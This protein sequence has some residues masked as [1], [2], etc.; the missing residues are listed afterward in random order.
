MLH[1]G[2]RIELTTDPEDFAVCAQ[3]MSATD[4]WI[5]MGVD[6]EQCL[7]AFDGSHREVFVLKKEREVI[8]FVIIQ[9]LGT[10]KGY[11]QTLAINAANRGAGYGTLL[12]QFCAERILQYSPNI[13]ICVS[14]FNTK[15]LQLYTKFGFELVGELKDFLKD[16]FSELLLRKTA[17][18]VTGYTPLP[19]KF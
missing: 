15:A 18:P 19:S 12:L 7:K 2:T 16:G 17:G 3:I 8:G 10:F 4:P 11:I 1:S 14:S 6:Y 5:T 13:F 9:P